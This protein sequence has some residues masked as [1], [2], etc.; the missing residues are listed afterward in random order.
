MRR[1]KF[2]KAFF[3]AVLL[4][5]TL[6]CIGMANAAGGCGPG[7]HSTWQGACVVDGWGTGAR[8]WNECP[9]YAQARPFCPYQYVWRK[10]YR[11]CAPAD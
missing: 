3:A 4:S 1:K 7:C 5:S 2:M 10:R 6:A 11:A 8:V 9:A